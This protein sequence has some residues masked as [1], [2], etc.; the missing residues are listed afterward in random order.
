MASTIDPALVKICDEIA[1]RGG[2]PRLPGVVSGV[3]V[4][5]VAPPAV[6]ASARLRGFQPEIDAVKTS[7]GNARRSR[8]SSEGLLPGTMGAGGDA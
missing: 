6:R 8:R 3:L 2:P 5:V 1:G 4:P 7:E